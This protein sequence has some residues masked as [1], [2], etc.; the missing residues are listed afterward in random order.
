MTFHAFVLRSLLAGMLLALPAPGHADSWA[1]PSLKV[2]ASTDGRAL[3]RMVP[4]DFSGGKRPEV[5]LYGYEVEDAQYALKNR[6]QLRNRIAPVD[7]LLTGQGELVALDE[8]GQVGQGT[9]LT[10]YAPDGVPRLQLDLEQLLGEQAAA[11][12]PASVSSRWWRCRKPL[13]NG[14]DSELV[15]RT[16]DNGELRVTLASGMVKYTSDS[17]ECS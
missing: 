8:W 5:E 13:L 3:V 2:V 16:Y 14:D 4:G 11:K 6:F 12:A 15:V 7:M 17:G 10:V 9:V 1:R